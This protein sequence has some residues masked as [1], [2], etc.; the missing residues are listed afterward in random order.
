MF[1]LIDIK[2]AQ[3]AMIAKRDNVVAT[4]APAELIVILR[5]YSNLR[6]GRGRTFLIAIEDDP[7]QDIMID[8]WR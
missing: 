3:K 6:K 8:C 5:I 1:D 7:I 2:S 4:R